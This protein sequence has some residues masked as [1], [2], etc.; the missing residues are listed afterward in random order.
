[1]VGKAYRT[2]WGAIG[3]MQRNTLRSLRTSWNP[4]GNNNKNSKIPC[5]WTP[6]SLVNLFGHSQWAHWGKG[7]KKSLSFI[8]TYSNVEKLCYMDSWDGRSMKW[9][10]LTC[11]D[12][13]LNNIIYIFS[14]NGMIKLCQSCGPSTPYTIWNNFFW[15]CNYNGN[16]PINMHNI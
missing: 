6:I 13:W 16:Q 4:I 14:Y 2:R 12:F 11:N 3:N 9:Q 15:V 8:C 5:T 7:A 1:M 10:P